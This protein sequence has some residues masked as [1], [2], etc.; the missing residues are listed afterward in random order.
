MDEVL[1]ELPSLQSL[2]F[3]L[4]S[5]F[6]KVGTLLSGKHVDELYSGAL[7]ATAASYMGLVY[8]GADDDP[9]QLPD[10]VSAGLGK[11][12]EVEIDDELS[13]IF[14]QTK[15]NRLSPYGQHR[16]RK[17]LTEVRGVF[18]IKL[19]PDPPARVAPLVATPTKNARPHIPPQRPHAP[20][21]C[22]L[23]SNTVQTSEK[24]GSIYKNPAA[25]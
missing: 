12:R 3:D 17:T 9:I 14:D 21:L 19:G 15:M 20:A 24:I 23:I 18:R 4:K 16:M 22:A 5:Q 8:Q 6:E 13:A 7:K 2:R 11:D 25:R 1:L 10:A